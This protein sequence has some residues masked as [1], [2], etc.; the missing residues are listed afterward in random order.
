MGYYP[1]NAYGDALPPLFILD[2]KPTFE[3]NHNINHW[4]CIGLPEIV[5]EY[6][7]NNDYFGNLRRKNGLSAN[8]DIAYLLFSLN[9]ISLT[10]LTIFV[11]FY[12]VVNHNFTVKD[13]IKYLKCKTLA[14]ALYRRKVWHEVNVAANRMDKAAASSLLSLSRASTPSSKKA[15][16]QRKSPPEDH[17]VAGH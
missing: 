5:D 8:K 17:G 15:R 3:V 4:V 6:G 9:K 2:S 12:Q 13:A 16:G 10:I 7:L 11:V 1:T 14:T